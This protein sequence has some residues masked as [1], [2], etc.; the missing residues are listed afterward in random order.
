M[1]GS[2]LD[3]DWVSNVGDFNEISAPRSPAAALNRRIGIPK[4]L[5]LSARFLVMPEPG[6][7]TT[8]IGS[9]CKS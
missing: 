9:F 4:P 5:A 1:V 8:P 3:A 2:V 7:T 6:D